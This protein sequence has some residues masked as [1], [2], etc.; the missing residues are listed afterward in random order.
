MKEMVMGKRKCHY[1]R[2]LSNLKTRICRTETYP[3]KKKSKMDLKLP[4]VAIG[5]NLLVLLKEVTSVV[6]VKGEMMREFQFSESL[7]FRRHQPVQG[8]ILLAVTLR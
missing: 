6:K 2:K 1:L 5:R 4:I 8:L 7:V 3:L